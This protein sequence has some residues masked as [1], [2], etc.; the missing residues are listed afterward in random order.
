MQMLAFE[1]GR[2]NFADQIAFVW[3]ELT[4]DYGSTLSELRTTNNPAVAADI[5]MNTYEHPNAALEHQTRREANARN[6]FNEIYG[7]PV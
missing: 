3:H 5:V 1:G 2:P 7:N 6:V 4:T